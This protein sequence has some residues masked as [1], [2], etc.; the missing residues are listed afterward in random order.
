MPTLGAFLQ[1]YETARKGNAD[2]DQ[3]T[4][5]NFLKM[6]QMAQQQKE[7]AENRA[8]RMSL[9]EQAIADRAAGREATAGLQREGMAQR[10]ADATA[11]RQGRM[12]E[13]KMRLQDARLQG[14]DRLAM[15]RE[16]AKLSTDTRMTVAEMQGQTQR[17]IAGMRAETSPTAIKERDKV[18]GRTST[19]ALLDELEAD[20][21]KL[22]TQGSD[23]SPQ[24]SAVQ[25]IYN[26]VASSAPGQLV[27]GAVGTESQAVRD[28]INQ[29][30]ASLMA[31][32]KQATG[33]GA[34]QLNSN[35]ELQ[36]YLKMATDPTMSRE[37]N[38]KAINWLR[39]TYG[40]K[41]GA[42]PAPVAPAAP[43]A[44]GL[45]PAEQKELEALRKALG[46]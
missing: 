14:A 11:A 8:M 36:F 18:E 46:R 17:D 31:S 19:T 15:Q 35:V 4:L 5:A 44:G 6:Q 13:L 2:A 9:G 12:E 22:Q 23:I 30:R 28:S 45:S 32:I 40:T 41:G 37:A 29:K 38:K 27:A 1:G 39:N 25:N 3:Q 20:Y 7:L 42:A 24:R 26:R 10:S 34:T 16:L 21:G 33:M 43:A